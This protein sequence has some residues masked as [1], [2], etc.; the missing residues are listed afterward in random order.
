[1]GESENSRVEAHV[2]QYQI[3]FCDILATH[4]S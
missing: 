3:L 2:H 1:M 4:N